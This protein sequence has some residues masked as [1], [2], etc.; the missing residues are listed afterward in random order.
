MSHRM[1]IK[2]LYTARYEM[3]VIAEDHEAAKVRFK[4]AMIKAGYT[5]VELH[6]IES[7]GIPEPEAEKLE[8]NE[9]PLFFW[10]GGRQV[11]WH[12]P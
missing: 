4:E 9:E 5:D 11:K 7:E 3:E 6:H 12:K 10:T 1:K 8:G 2:V